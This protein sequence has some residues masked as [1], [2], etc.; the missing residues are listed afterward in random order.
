MFDEKSSMNSQLI[1]Y[2]LKLDNQDK[3]Q[4]LDVFRK[5]EFVA[6]A[7]RLSEKGRTMKKP[8]MKMDEIVSIIK[9]IRKKNARKS[10]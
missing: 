10:A 5:R 1:D 6:E 9:E 7:R 2:I 4:L 3:Q 8:K